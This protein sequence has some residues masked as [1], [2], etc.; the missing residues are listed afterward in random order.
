MV[1]LVYQ[2]VM[3]L[4]ILVEGETLQHG[5]CKTL[6]D[7]FDV[8]LRIEL[9][10]PNPVKAFDGCYMGTNETIWDVDM[11]AHNDSII[12]EWGLVWFIGKYS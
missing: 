11:L 6:V 8:S 10:S 7:M 2:R 5:S 9:N 4:Y 1:M 3:F 12:K